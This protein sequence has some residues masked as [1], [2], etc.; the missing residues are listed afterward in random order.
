MFSVD[1]VAQTQSVDLA[2]L[3]VAAEVDIPDFISPPEPTI[4]LGYGLDF[5]ISGLKSEILVCT[6]IGS[7]LSPSC[8]P[9]L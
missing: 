4:N 1:L 6:S 3:S 8:F 5:D 2:G 9:V 7:S